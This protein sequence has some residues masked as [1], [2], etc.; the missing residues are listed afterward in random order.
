MQELNFPLYKFRLKNSENKLYIFDI[1]RKKFILLQ[2]EEWVRQNVVRFLI[3]EKNYPKSLIN[4]EKRLTINGLTKRYD[5]VVF[6]PNGQIFLIVECKS[7]QVEITQA[8][9]DQ[10]AR[11]NLSLKADNMMITNGLRHYFCRL[12]YENKSYVFLE[13]LPKFPSKKE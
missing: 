10:I 8:V 3:E 12:D 5:V 7:P 9:F 2:P 11:Y 1:I 6:Y 4:V 13:D